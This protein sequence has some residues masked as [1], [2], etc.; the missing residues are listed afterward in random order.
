MKEIKQDNA[1][2]TQDFILLLVV[3]LVIPLS[4]VLGSRRCPCHGRLLPTMC[5]SVAMWAHWCQVGV[6]GGK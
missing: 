5:P 4:E 3:V 1:K 2:E 6:A